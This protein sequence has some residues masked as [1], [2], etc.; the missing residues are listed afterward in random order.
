MIIGTSTNSSLE[1]KTLIRSFDLTR[2]SQNQ[3]CACPTAG[4]TSFCLSLKLNRLQLRLS[5][6]QIRIQLLQKSLSNLQFHE[7]HLLLFQVTEFCV[8]NLLWIT[9]NYTL[10][11]RENA[12]RWDERLRP[13]SQNSL[14]ELSPQEAPIMA[15]ALQLRHYSSKLSFHPRLL[16]PNAILWSRH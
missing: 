16:H 3:S 12:K 15:M 1:K 2:L 8:I 11:L 4:G 10:V 5:Q 13:S 6:L 7:Q 14:R 9:K